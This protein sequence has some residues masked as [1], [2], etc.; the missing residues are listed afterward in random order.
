MFFFS[1]RHLHNIT[2]DVYWPTDYEDQNPSWGVNGSLPTQEIPCSLRNK[3]GRYYW[4]WRYSQWH[5]FRYL[6]HTLSYNIIAWFLQQQR[7]LTVKLYQI[8]CLPQQSS[9]TIKS[10]DGWDKPHSFRDPLWPA[11]SGS[12]LGMSLVMET[13]QISQTM[14]RNQTFKWVIARHGFISIYLPSELR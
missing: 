4:T 1:A 2:K 11:L 14:S 10:R 5:Y 13:R 12:K 8:L 6:F 3:K 7:H 9:G